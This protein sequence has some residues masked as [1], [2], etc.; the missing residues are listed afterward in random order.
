MALDINTFSNGRP[1]SRCAEGQGNGFSP[2]R[3]VVDCNL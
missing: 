1:P 2:C 3:N